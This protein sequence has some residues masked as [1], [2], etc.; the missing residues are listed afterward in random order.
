MHG[1]L[2]TEPPPG[3]TEKPVPVPLGVSSPPSHAGGLLAPK[4]LLELGEVWV[5]FLQNL[6]QSGFLWNKGNSSPSVTGQL[7]GEVCML[8]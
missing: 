6:P 2:C 5:F 3:L 1:P 8:I 7:P 4:Q